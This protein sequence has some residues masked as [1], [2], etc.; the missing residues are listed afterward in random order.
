MTDEEKEIVERIKSTV[1]ANAPD[2]KVILYG[3]RARGDAHEE[4]DWDL[5][6]LL[7]KEKVLPADYD[8]TSFVLFLLGLN[9]N[10]S[11][12]VCLYTTAEW[13]KRSFTIFYKNIKEEG[14]VLYDAN[15][16]RT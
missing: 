6:V 16:R 15:S 7:N 3:S 9:F 13:E 1:K 8:R 14:I 12:E 11:I 10:T 4:S 2:A 5:L